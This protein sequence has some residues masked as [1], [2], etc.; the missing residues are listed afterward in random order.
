MEIIY[1][2]FV[3]LYSCL[4]QFI[5]TTDNAVQNVFF[6]TRIVSKNVLAAVPILATRGLCLPVGLAG[7][8]LAADH[9]QVSAV[10]S[11]L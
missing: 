6:R 10:C 4:C 1:V 11:T 2:F 3:L 7:W 8:Q 9:L 5:A